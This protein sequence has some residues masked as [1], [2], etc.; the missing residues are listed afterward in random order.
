MKVFD[1]IL[2]TSENH[3]LRTFEI[4]SVLLQAI[5]GRKGNGGIGCDRGESGGE[6]SHVWKKRLGDERKDESGW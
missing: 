5:M 6:T 4:H 2:T 1:C 3:S